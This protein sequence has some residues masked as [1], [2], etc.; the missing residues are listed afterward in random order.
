MYLSTRTGW[1]RLR[2]ARHQQRFHCLGFSRPGVLRAPWMPV[3][4]FF[5]GLSPEQAALVLR[6]RAEQLGEEPPP[7]S[8]LD[9]RWPVVMQHAQ[10]ASGLALDGIDPMNA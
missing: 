10:D 3:E 7:L 2:V 8:Q 4:H 6:L 5:L 9:H 1:L